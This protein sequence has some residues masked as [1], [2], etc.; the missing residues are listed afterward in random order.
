[1]VAHHT[2]AMI[3]PHMTLTHPMEA[4]LMVTR[5]HHMIPTQLM[6]THHTIATRHMIPTQLMATRHMIAMIILLMD[7]RT[8]P[9]IPMV[10][11]RL[12]IPMSLAKILM[13]VLRLM[14][15]I[16]Q[17]RNKHHP[18][19]LIVHLKMKLRPNHLHLQQKMTLHQ[20]NLLQNA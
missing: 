19:T 8:L 18:M 6:P 13:E 2:I 20:Q 5:H 17:L 3:L 4:Q 14:T 12:M 16:L 9:T 1:M 7:H 11:P 10:T 15:H